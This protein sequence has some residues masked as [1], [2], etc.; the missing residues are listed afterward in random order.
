[1]RTLLRRCVALAALVALIGV[2][3]ASASVGSKKISEEKY[4]KTLCTTLGRLFASQKYLVDQYNALPA[5][6]AS[7]LQQQAGALVDSFVRDLE[8]ASARLRAVHPAVDGG[9]KISKSFVGF[10]DGRR[11]QVQAA[12]AKLRAADP[13]S[14][15]FLVELRTFETSLT[16]LEAGARDPLS[17]IH[18]QDLLRALKKEK[19]C[20]GVVTVS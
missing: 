13:Q 7:V 12:L 6:E 18:N 4:A 5:D 2:G 1:M 10:V 16:L 8:H 3:T 14:P 11:D 17:S 19:S 15:A 9:K 20:R